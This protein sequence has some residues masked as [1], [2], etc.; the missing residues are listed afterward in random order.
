[1]PKKDSI[2]LDNVEKTIDLKLTGNM[3]DYVWK[4]NNQTWPNVTPIELKYGKMH[5]F[6]IDNETE[7]SHP[8][9][10]YDYDFKVVKING[11]SIDDGVIRDTL[12]V[13]PK[14]SVTIALKANELGKWFIHYHMHSG[15]MTFIETKRTNV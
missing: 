15:M 5:L 7:M 14:S 2:K 9:H 1:M 13:E 8:I 6:E 4:I 3:K 11:K 12:Y 10:I